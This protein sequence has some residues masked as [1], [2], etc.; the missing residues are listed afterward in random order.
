M[1]DQ[2][3]NMDADVIILA[4]GSVRLPLWHR[5]CKDAALQSMRL[6]TDRRLVPFSTL[7][8]MGTRSE[9]TSNHTVIKRI[10]LYKIF[11]LIGGYHHES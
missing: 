11:K 2:L 7:Y 8:G 3:R 9:T 5:S 4:T 10:A 6:A 1:A